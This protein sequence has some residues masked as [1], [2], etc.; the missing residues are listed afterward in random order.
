[1]TAP[2][3]GTV[4]GLNCPNCGAAITLRTGSVAQTVV[5]DS[6]HAVLDAQDPNLRVLQKAQQQMKFKPI[7]PLGTRGTFKGDPYEAIGFQ[8]RSIT[9][10][11]LDYYWREYV[12]W[13]PYKGFRYLTEYDGHWNDVLIAKSPHAEKGGKQPTI[14]Y[15]GQT[16]RHFQSAIATTRF[17]LGEFPWQVRS[18]D[19]ANVRD[20]VSPPYMLSEESTVEETTW[21]VGT[22]VAPQYIW[23]AFK[24]PGKPSAPR[25]TYANQPNP[26]AG[27]WTGIGQAFAVLAALV[28]LLLILR[29]VTAQRGEMFVGRYSF[30]PSAVSAESTAFVTRLFDVTGHT[31]NVEVR[32]ETDLS[33]NW[34]YFNFALID[35]RN[36]TAYDFGRE[37][38]YYYGYDSDGSWS[39]GS[40]RDVSY[41]PSV[42][43]GRYYLRVQPEG[44][45]KYRGLVGY[46]VRLRRDVPRY[47]YYAIAMFLLLVPPAL[48]AFRH[49]SFESARWKESDYAPES[50]DE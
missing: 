1:V 8:V 31:S 46:T 42:P 15:I 21:S 20:F 5:C 36:G 13:N 7:I 27:S 37:V 6:C 26:N 10:D 19:T 24:L 9:V 48:A 35:D 50:G 39:E 22:Y 2:K 34:A 17:I 29:S 33:N 23:E 25:G 32:I 40:R 30:A 12:L 44:D 16:F 38:S 3:T 49:W 47:V 43:A 41:V 28:L 18:G 45:P 11:D 4:R 14:E